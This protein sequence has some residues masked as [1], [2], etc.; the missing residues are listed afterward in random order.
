M[1]KKMERIISAANEQS[2]NN[3]FISNKDSNLDDFLNKK[4][5]KKLK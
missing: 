2:N 5:A 1:K 4:E 3:I